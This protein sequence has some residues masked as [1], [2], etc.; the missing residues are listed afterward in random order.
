MKKIF[1]AALTCAMVSLTSCDKLKDATSRDIKVNNVKF[2]FAATSSNAT[3]TRGAIETRVG[4]DNTFTVTRLVN[5]TELGN[6]E[7]TEY[8]AKIS[9]VAVNSPLLKITASPSGSY[10]V[11]DVTVTAEGV[12]G[13]LSVP[14]YT[15]GSA[16]TP[17]TNMNAYTAA[18]VTKLISAKLVSVTVSGK[19]DAPAGTVVRISYES[20][21]L[22]TASLL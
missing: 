21:L 12:T 10:T 5:I 9:K 22:L 16:F 8:A 3:G 4:T 6:A 2:E 13:T 15:L 11:A 1:F 19:T 14:S 17:P 7:I 20:D 18:F